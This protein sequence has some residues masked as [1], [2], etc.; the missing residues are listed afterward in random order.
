MTTLKTAVMAVIV[1]LMMVGAVEVRGVLSASAGSG[2]SP[3]GS[4]QSFAVLG[5]AIVT[6][7]GGTVVNGD[8]GVSPATAITGF[9]P[10]LVL[11]GTIHSADPVASRAQ[12][13]AGIANTQFKAMPCL[14]FNNL[15][16]RVLGTDV[17]SLPP[18]VYCFDT[19][20][21]LTG[22]LFLTGAGPW[23][24]QTGSTLTTAAN[25][26]V[27]VA[28]AGATCSGA[29]VF[30]QVGSSAT[31]GVGTTF[32]GTI[33]ALASVTVMN[34]VS[35]SGSV[36]ALTAAV[37]LDRNAISVCNPAPVTPNESPVADAGPDRVVPLA[38]LV[39]LD[40]SA[41]SDDGLLHTPSYSWVSDTG[42]S[43]NGIVATVLLPLGTH[44]FTLTVND[45]EFS[46]SDSVT[47][48]VMDTPGSAQSPLGS[49]QS[50]AVLGASIVTNTGPTVVTGDLG[51][52]P[53]IAITGFPPGVVVGTIHAADPIAAQAQADAGFANGQLRAMA[54][55]ATNHLT[56]RVLGTTVL[57]LPP[58]VYCFDTSAQ[59]TGTLF[60]T[61]AGPWVFQVGTTLTTASNA[62][63]VVLDAGAE[64]QRVERLLAGWQ[65]RDA[66]H[67]HAVRR[68]HPGTRQRHGDDRRQRVRKRAGAHRSGDAGYQRRLRPRLRCDTGQPVSR[69]RRRPRSSGPIRQP[70]H[71]GRQRLE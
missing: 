5:A 59:L 17:L 46:A 43:A 52:S 10:G 24:F 53:G 62:A 69:S 66:R 13:D 27:V 71:A 44:V 12:L 63:I 38:S 68:D 23:I 64:L 16:G 29:K 39:T 25:A 45:G 7:I 70:R 60:L 9:P 14:P 19:S 51:V 21:Q 20:A 1:P 18:G 47:I 26:A 28:D 42:F 55:P 49:A 4:A 11:G 57:S 22:T 2:P 30:W 54:C 32:A 35:V 41:S 37:T 15:T 6:S 40:G 67:G 61:G 56:G 50:F 8:L 36:I 33:L 34:G 58:G 3:L 31:L 48:V 65:L